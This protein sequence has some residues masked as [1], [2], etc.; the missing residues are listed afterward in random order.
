[1][2]NSKKSSINN[3]EVTWLE[4]ILKNI[5]YINS[6]NYTELVTVKKEIVKKNIVEKILCEYENCTNIL[7]DKS[8]YWSTFFLDTNETKKCCIS[9]FNKYS[10]SN[11][12][13]KHISTTIHI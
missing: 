13:I 9:C 8:Y 3:G 5:Y 6:N 11:G 2:K 12:N 7:S 1:M 4:I 10:N